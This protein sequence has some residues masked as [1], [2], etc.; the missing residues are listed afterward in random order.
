[1]IRQLRNK[2]RLRLKSLALLTFFLMVVSVSM[3]APGVV[4]EPYTEATSFIQSRF[5]LW[6]N[7]ERM[8]DPAF[9]VILINPN[10][11]A[12]YE[13]DIDG[14]ITTGLVNYSEV[15]DFD[16]TGQDIIYYLEVKIDNQTVLLAGEI[17]L[18]E[19]L[20]S[21]GVARPGS[22]FTISLAP[23]EWTEKEWNIVFSI[24]LSSLLAMFIGYRIAKRYRKLHGVKEVR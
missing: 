10:G 11:S 15:V 16:Y 9:S 7:T 18:L 4:A 2:P 23:W 1:M 13:I 21:S 6:D 24:I 14:N 8:I 17:V 12:Y 19:G 3:I 20:S 22:P 5:I